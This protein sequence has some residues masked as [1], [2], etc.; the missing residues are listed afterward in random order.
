VVRCADLAVEGGGRREAGS[1]LTSR[2]S[3]S[4]FCGGRLLRLR[5]GRPERGQVG[6]PRGVAA[7]RRGRGGAGVAE[8]DEGIET[9]GRQWM[10]GGLSGRAMCSQ[11]RSAPMDGRLRLE[12]DFDDISRFIYD[13]PVYK[14]VT[15]N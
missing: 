15:S 7:E 10:L 14:L 4:G 1:H 11:T 6:A 9:D 8:C 5:R 3:G 12:C 13:V 2:R